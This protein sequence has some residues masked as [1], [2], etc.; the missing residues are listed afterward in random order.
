[1][2][3]GELYLLAAT[4]AVIVVLFASSDESLFSPQVNV[5]DNSGQLTPA[6]FDDPNIIPSEPNPNAEVIPCGSSKSDSF[7]GNL[8]VKTVKINCGLTASWNED[9]CSG[10]CALALSQEI[11]RQINAACEP[12]IPA[13]LEQLAN[14]FVCESCGSGCQQKDSYS[15]TA[16]NDDSGWKV[17]KNKNGWWECTVY[18][19]TNY[20]GE[21]KRD[22]IGSCAP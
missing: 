11:E 1:M 16:M 5:M 18:I 21:V 10:V 12:Q 8:I 7:Q 4:F 15:C 19:R 6:P 3:R 2:R 13:K 9:L 20:V 22:C 14:N 17:T